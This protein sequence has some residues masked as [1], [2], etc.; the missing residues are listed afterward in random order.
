MTGNPEIL[1]ENRTENNKKAIYYFWIGFVVYSLSFTVYSSFNVKFF[2]YG[3]LQVIGL[4]FLVP[5][6][7]KLVHWNFDSNYLKILYSIYI[8]WLFTVIIRGFQFDFK[9][10]K[11]MLFDAR[12]G[13]FL[14]F[15]PLILLF[16]IN[17]FDY[18]KAFD[19]IVILGLAYIILILLFLKDPLNPNLDNISSIRILENFSQGLSL[20]SGLIILTYLYH[21]KKRILLA[22]FVII[23]T[24]FLATVN[25]RRGLMF[26]TL[27]ILLVSCLIYVFS[28]KR[29]LFKIIFS[30]LLIPVIYFLGITLYNENRSGIFANITERID[31]NTRSVIEG[32]FFLDMNTQDLLLG[33]GVNG[34]Y[35]CPEIDI[36]SLTGY[37][38][39]I[40][41]GFLQIILK[42]GLISL[43]LLLLIAIPAMFKGIFYSKNIL[44]KAAGV[45]IFLFLI[46]SYPATITSFTM[47]YL[48]VWISIG[49]CYSKDLRN[50]PDSTLIEMLSN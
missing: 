10:I 30:L 5:S 6:A 33:R 41:T 46:D 29:K 17:L 43:G 32:Y 39:A 20:P 8:C 16:P 49:I 12:N 1:T 3:S 26:M 38:N 28:H 35:F 45:W 15:V 44:S 42:G 50:I 13:I 47:H 27:S 21:S 4:I 19:V 31:E 11:D 14:Y 9:F 18:K 2:L 24:F 25:A 36:N 34:Q 23:I 22:L 37:R 48:L 40:E 7:A